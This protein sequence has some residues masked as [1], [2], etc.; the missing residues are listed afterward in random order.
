MA[1]Q[2]PTG[3][4]VR[5]SAYLIETFVSR[6]LPVGKGAIPF[7]ERQPRRTTTEMRRI[8]GAGHVAVGFW[9]DRPTVVSDVRQITA[10]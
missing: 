6:C 7:V 3:V 5:N 10:D 1:L 4:H 2:Y 9:R 8:T